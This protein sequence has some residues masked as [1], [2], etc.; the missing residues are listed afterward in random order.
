V[1]NVEREN[2]TARHLILAMREGFS[3]WSPVKVWPSLLRLDLSAMSAPSTS[4]EATV[5][6]RYSIFAAQAV[7]CGVRK[8]DPKPVL[9]P[10]IFGTVV[11]D[12][13]PG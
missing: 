11:A 12:A 9:L 1:G 6:P 2:R 13:S 8:R 3:K 10:E 5:D 7:G 4:P